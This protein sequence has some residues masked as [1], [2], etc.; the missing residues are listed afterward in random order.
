MILI[1]SLLFNIAFYGWTG[2]M[3]FGIL[4]SLLL[5]RPRMIQAVLF[6]LRSVYFLERH[7]LGLDYE[8]RGAE[9][10]PKGPFVLAAKHQSAWE[11]MKLHLLVHDPAIVLKR[12]LL[13]IPIWGWYA[14]K[15]Q[16]IAVDRGARGKAV[17]SMLRGARRTAAE[18]RPIV[19]FPQGTRVAPGTA[20]PY[21]PGAAILYEDLGIPI[22]PMALNAGVY[23][24]R[25]SFRKRPGRIVVEFLPPI[26]PGLTRAQAMAELET[27][28]EA[29]TDRLVVSAGGPPTPGI[30][31]N[32]A[33]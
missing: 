25:R 4:W 19:I 13:W 15:A 12:E 30:T 5:P 18:G 27:R 3:C 33:A 6:W 21:R 16:M 7:I 11:T 8:V 17:S 9:H 26:L 22:V 20:R 28:L 1:R 10:L 29:A 2:F 23:W 24:P 32:A 14:A 31:T